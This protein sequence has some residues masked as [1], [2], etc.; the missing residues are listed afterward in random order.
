MVFGCHSGTGETIKKN[1]EHQQESWI[2]EDTNSEKKMK[3]VP[4]EKT[5]LDQQTVLY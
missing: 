5:I 1:K 2:P 4:A 3:G